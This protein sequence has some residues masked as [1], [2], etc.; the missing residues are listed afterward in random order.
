MC[1]GLTPMSAESKRKARCTSQKKEK[2]NGVERTVVVDLENR[3]SHVAT[4]EEMAQGR[5]FKDY[6]EYVATNG[7]PNVRQKKMFS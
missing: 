4:E 7:E 1:N 5:F 3:S 2:A 6:D